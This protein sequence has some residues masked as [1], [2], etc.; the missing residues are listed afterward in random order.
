M[1]DVGWLS[2]FQTR[3][4]R[5][6]LT[7]QAEGLVRRKLAELELEVDRSQGWARGGT[8]QEARA[9]FPTRHCT[10]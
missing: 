6:P 10:V 2:A 1:P 5:V 3:S 4:T 8:K 9:R 7:V